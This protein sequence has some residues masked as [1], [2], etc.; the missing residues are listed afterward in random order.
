MYFG[1]R[2]KEKQTSLYFD[3]EGNLYPSKR[4]P[5]NDLEKYSGSLK[6]FYLSN[7]GVFSEIKSDYQ[8]PDGLAFDQALDSLN[9]A[10]FSST[11]DLSSE[12][13]PTFLIHGFRK[14][15][16]PLNN[17]RTSQQD[18][19][20]IMASLPTLMTKNF[21]LVYW[22]GLYDCCIGANFSENKRIFEA[23]EQ[24]QQN[25]QKVGK[26][27]GKLIEQSKIKEMEMLSFSLGAQVIN[28]VI[29]Q[30]INT[31]VKVHATLVEPAMAGQN[32]VDSFENGS[33]QLQ[34]SL[35][36]V[37]NEEDFVLKKKD[38]KVSIFGPGPFRYG[39]TT[40]GCNYDNDAELTKELLERKNISCQLLNFSFIGKTHR[41]PNYFRPPHATLIWN[42]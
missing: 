35:T 28:S 19:D 27:L 5:N 7:P 9:W 32:L 11:L 39:I 22:D 42:N 30:L 38:P 29:A 37:F 6:D 12:L 17:D 18:F 34:I 33:G 40:L 36:I 31:P 4:L 10:I 21:V 2:T 8:L 15:Y 1:E 14:S 41:V 24:A 16:L 20:S 13:V 26:S 25:A 3:A 23:F